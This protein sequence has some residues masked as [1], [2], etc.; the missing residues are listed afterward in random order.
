MRLISDISLDGSFTQV[1]LPRRLSYVYTASRDLY[2]LH[3]HVSV[4]ISPRLDL[5]GLALFLLLITP[6]TLLFFFFFVCY[7]SQGGLH[8]L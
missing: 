3:I 8:C 4:C 2:I 1:L 5:V 6:F 7:S